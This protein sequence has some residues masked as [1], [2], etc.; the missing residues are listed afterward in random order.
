M[1][2]D[3]FLIELEATQR[4]NPLKSATTR[5]KIQIQDVNDNRPLFKTGHFEK[6]I[7]ENVPNGADIVKF[8]A[9]DKDSVRR[10]FFIYHIFTFEGEKMFYFHY[11]FLQGE[12]GRFLYSL[13][14]PSGA[15]E[16]NQNTGALTMKNGAKF[17]RE[18]YKNG[19]IDLVIGTLEFK[20]SVLPIGEQQTNST[21]KVRIHVK[22]DNDNSPVFLPSK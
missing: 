4:D 3:E 13:N 1:D 20:P 17:D 16:I 14:D 10:P 6:S 5:V 12:N 7:L 2:S 15:F 21:V 8:T 22:D 19:Y 9:I 11:L 18:K